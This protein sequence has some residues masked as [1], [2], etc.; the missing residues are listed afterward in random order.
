[1]PSARQEA[2]KG[3]L[4]FIKRMVAP[5]E[6]AAEALAKFDAGS[7]MSKAENIAAGLYHPIGEGKKLNVPFSRMT[8]TVV[9][10]PNVIMHQGRIITP[11]QAVKDRMGF[12]PLI[13]DRAE[14]GKILTHVNNRKAKYET[15]LTGGGKYGQANYDPVMEKSSAWESGKGKV[16]TLR[17]RITD[18]AESGYQPVGVFSPGS[19]V[20]VDFNTMM[21]HALLGQ[22]DQTDTTKK[23]VKQFDKEVKS[24]YPDWVGITSPEA[25]AQL[26]DKGNGVLRTVFTKTMGKDD[27]QA[28]GFPDVPSV[29]KAI[30]D[31]DLFDTE[32]GTLGQNLAVFDP[33][34]A[35]VAAPKNP[36]AYPLS[37]SGQNIGKMDETEKFSDFFTTAN[38]RRRLL[39]SDPAGDYRSF[40]L[41]Q[42]IQYAD[43]EWLNNLRENRRLRDEAIKKGGY[44]KGGAIHGDDQELKDMIADHLD[45]QSHDQ[46]LRAMVDNHLAGGGVPK[47]IAK[48]FF[49]KLFGNDVL[50]MATRDANL[51]K[52]LAPSAEKRRMYHGSK[53]PNIKEFKTR[54]EMTDES[55]MTGHYADERDAVF[56]SP[57]PQFTKHFSQEGY[58]DTHQAPTTY[59]VH[60]QIEKPFDFDNPEHLEK[61]KETY[62]DMYHNPDSDLY[63]PHMLPSERSMAIHTFNK[64]VDNLPSDENN[65]ARIENQDFQDVLKDLGFDSFYTRERGTK[66]LGVYEPNQI[67]SAIGNRGTYDINE[68]DI[69]K[70]G[71]GVIHMASAGRVGRGIAKGFKSIFGGADEIA[72][73]IQGGT[74]RF[75]EQ[76]GGNTIMKETGG[77]WLTGSVEKGLQPLR[78]RTPGGKDP[79]EAITKLKKDFPENTD[80]YGV[81]RPEYVGG[82]IGRLEQDVALNKWL[83]SNLTNYVK[84]QMGTA[85]DP[86][87]KLAEEGVTHLPKNNFA[88]NIWVPEEL[89]QRRKQFG[90]PE[91]EIATSNLAKTWEQMA[92]EA[93]NPSRAGEHTKPLSQ[94]EHRQG[95]RSNIESNPWLTKIDP[96]T[97]IYRPEQEESFGSL[98]FDHIMD[99]L[100][101]DVT[102]GRIRPEQLSKVSMEQA[103]R[104]THEFDQ[105]MAKRMAETQVKNTAGMP[106]HKEYPEEGY[107]WIQLSQPEELPKGWSKEASGAYV[108]PN[109]ERTIVNPSRQTLE[110]SLK[111][112]GDTMGHCVGSYC[113]DVAEGNSKIYSLRDAKGEPHVTIE[114]E[115]SSKHN[116]GYGMEGREDFP[117]DF[118]YESGSITPEQ[119]QQI[120]QRAKQLFKPESTKDVGNHRMDVFQ[121]AADEVLG[122]P[123]D[124]IV[125]IKGKGNA[126]PKEDYLPFVQDFVKSGK[127]SDVGDIQNTGLVKH[128]DTGKYVTREQR[129]AEVLAEPDLPANG[130]AE[131]GGAFKTIQWAKPQNFD[132]GGIASPEEESIGYSSEPSKMYKEVKQS[133]SN[134]YDRI[135]SSARARAQYAKIL[136]AQAAGTLADTASI[137]TPLINSEGLANA[138]PIAKMV[139]TGITGSPVLGK[140]ESVLSNERKPYSLSDALSTKSGDPIGGSEHIIKKAQEAGLMYGKPINVLD[141]SGYPVV[142]PQTGEPYESRSGRFSPI[143]EIGGSI[144]GGLG[145]SKAGKGAV[146]AAQGFGKGFNKGYARAM[147]RQELPFLKELGYDSA[148]DQQSVQPRA[149]SG[150]T[151]LRAR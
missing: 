56:L 65:W 91:D 46:E 70:A 73:A 61:V 51:Q 123:A 124:R 125:Q 106:V 85:D 82:Q 17:N 111:Y 26:M 94:M 29:R 102:D 139:M 99:V 96:S 50:P 22:F 92:D 52:F 25:E 9:D 149:L 75:G 128:P 103:V 55:M 86:V 147:S 39:S 58:T 101:Q 148:L 142:D 36:S 76:A 34:G 30:S 38:E 117:K 44:A 93:I 130:M 90:F 42:P 120:Y 115:P 62:L 150:L 43:E 37:M 109:G 118:R 116:I 18:I 6:A 66:N 132:G 135:K 144:L 127:W 14:T 33:T 49:K 89:A 100:R 21:P 3:G 140:R 19:H 57:E 114:T 35:L 41:S 79:V 54:K 119:Q 97:P 98:G 20:Q 8:S 110:D 67:K 72:P 104:R 95:Y 80:P 136:A 4:N 105:E 138:F 88:D 27:Y 48:G 122:K 53:E 126:A 47:A 143:T 28:G 69:N 87:R 40:E 74:R 10:N 15:P 77:N 134:D 1:M 129:R 137:V 24:I 5:N 113:D 133:L 83:D 2:V 13:G 59:P 78:R 32:I 60:V 12:F 63:D 31:P 64:R 107:K 108:G 45:S 84:K 23:L 81:Q 121:Q 16:G 146:K 112:E 68:A 131:G 141:E 151:Q 71:G 11:E 145:L 7:K